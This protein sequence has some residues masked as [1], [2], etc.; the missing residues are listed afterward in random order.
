MKIINIIPSKSDG[1]RALIGNFLANNTCEVIMDLKSEDI[2]AT[3][4]CLRAL[5]NG[6]RDLY[7]KESGS[8]FRFLL[9]II[10]ALNLDVN[11]NLEG[12]LYKRPLSPL[13]EELVMHGMEL[14]PQGSNPFRAYG[15]LKPGEYNIRGDISS[16]FITGLLF[17]L[18]LLDGDS[19]INIIGKLE[20]EPYINMTIKTLKAFNI[21]IIKKDYEYFVKGGQKYFTEQDYFVEG[22][23]SNG[24]VW[25]VLGALAEDEI[26]VKGLDLKSEQGDKKIIE[27]IRDFGGEIEITD[28]GIISKKADLKG[29]N[30]DGSQIPDLIPIISILASR[31]RG[32]TII[33]NIKRLKYKESDRIKAIADTLKKLGVEVIADD[34]SLKITETK[35]PFKA[36]E[37]D[38]FND[39]RIVMALAIAGMFSD[40]EIEIEGK[41]AINKSYLNFFEE[42][43]KLI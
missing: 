22:D 1:H 36:G 8:T 29:I 28:E 41:S 2:L 19:K 5:E 16:Q 30:L 31:A 42:L 23:W 38:S 20:S 33:K 24:A 26:M 40:G 15:K 14:S 27:I 7:P 25:L 35:E 6:E 43:E 11:F 4:S 17:A 37:Y 12:R 21:D 39:H 10:G 18:P 3:K 9:P 34:D 32:K 13:Y